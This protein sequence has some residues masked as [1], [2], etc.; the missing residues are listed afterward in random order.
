MGQRWRDP[1]GYAPTWPKVAVLV[2]LLLVAYFGAR[3]CQ[4]DQI[5][6]SQD[7][8]VAMA[9]EQVDFEPTRTQIRLLRQGL[10]REPFWF[11]SLAIPVGDDPDA[12]RFRRLTLVQIDARTGEIVNV[13]QEVPS[14]DAEEPPGAEQPEQAGEPQ[15]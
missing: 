5:K 1:K 7:E 11:V 14:E 15:Q 12:D 10:N 8:A 4:D 2:A 9:T 13:D 3:S 6:V